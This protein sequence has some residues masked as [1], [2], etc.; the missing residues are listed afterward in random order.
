MSHELASPGPA[1][2]RPT[3]SGHNRLDL[4]SPSPASLRLTVSGHNRLDFTSPS[5]ASPQ[6][7]VSGHNRLDLT[8]TCPASHRLTVSGHNRLDI[9]SPCLASPQCLRP[10]SPRRVTPPFASPCSTSKASPCRDVPRYPFPRPVRPPLT[11]HWRR[12]EEEAGH[13]TRN[14]LSV[15]PASPWEP[16][17]PVSIQ[18]VLMNPEVG[19]SIFGHNHCPGRYMY[20]ENHVADGVMAQSDSFAPTYSLIPYVCTPWWVGSNIYP[21]PVYGLENQFSNAYRDFGGPSAGYS[22]TPLENRLGATERIP[23]AFLGLTPNNH[24]PSTTVVQQP[25]EATTPLP[26][27]IPSPYLGLTSNVTFDDEG[28]MILD[29]LDPVLQRIPRSNLDTTT[30]MTFDDVVMRLDADLE[31]ATTRMTFDDV[32]MILDADLEDAVGNVESRV[33]S[34]AA[35]AQETIDVSLRSNTGLTEEAITMLLKTRISEQPSTS[36]N[37]HEAATCVICQ[38]DI[39]GKQLIGRLECGHE[40]HSECIKKWIQVKNECPMCKSQVLPIEGFFKI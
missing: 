23:R 21:A 5:P 36:E 39:E 19:Y 9:T 4:T 2:A 34:D 26:E 1:S 28:A 6:L 40:Y 32:V 31:E 33:Q 22:T 15:G 3:V 30:R 37:N 10:Q 18:P 27:R 13:C 38:D 7:T 17:Q 35:F 20:H 24:V 14:Y 12:E 11:T 29:F 8:L 16:D 25:R